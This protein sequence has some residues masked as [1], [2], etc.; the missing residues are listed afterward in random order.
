MSSIRGSQF[1]QGFAQIGFQHFVGTGAVGGGE[2]LF[3]GSV[4]ATGTSLS[5]DVEVCPS[6]ACEEPN[7]ERCAMPSSLPYTATEDS[8]VTVQ[9]AEDGSTVV[10]TYD[11][12]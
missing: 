4:A 2:R 7:D 6:S 3:I 1:S 12:Q 5:F 10:T 9:A 11:R 8:L